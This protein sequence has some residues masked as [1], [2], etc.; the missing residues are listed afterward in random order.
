MEGADPRRI[1]HVTVFARHGFDDNEVKALSGF[2]YLDMEEMKLRVQMIGLGRERDFR[3]PLFEKSVEWI[4]ATPFVG[5]SHIGGRSHGRGRY[6]RKAL[7]RECLRFTG[8]SAI[9]TEVQAQARRLCYGSA[10]GTAGPMPWEFRRARLGKAE[11]GYRRPCGYFHLKFAEPVSGPVSLGY[12][13]HFGMG[14]FVPV[15]E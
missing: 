15:G 11:D 9:V 2:S 12:S 14:Q 1:T 5:P 13:S 4:S 6:M 7:R 8:V 3:C 10:I